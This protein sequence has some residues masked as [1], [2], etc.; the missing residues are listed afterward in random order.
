MGI[1][2]GGKNSL[3]WGYEASGN[4]FD[5]LG[6]HAILG[7]TFTPEDDRKSSPRPVI[8]ISYASWQSRFAGDPHIVGQAAKLNGMDYTILGV[9]PR[10]F[11]GNRIAVDGRILGSDGHGAPDRARK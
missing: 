8:V 7:R 10:G 4:Y 9:A 11:F 1:S 2:H 6:V 5:V 3:I